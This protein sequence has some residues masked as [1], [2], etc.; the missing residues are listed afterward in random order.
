[1][2]SSPSPQKKPSSKKWVV[3]PTVILVLIVLSACLLTANYNTDTPPSREFYVGVEI[4]Y[5]SYSDLTAMVDEVKG[6]TNLVVLG[7]PEVSINQTLLDMSCNYIYD[8]GLHF[9]VLFTNLTQYKDWQNST[10]AQWV[11]DAKQRYGDRFL[12]VYRWDEAGGD[13]LDRSKYQEVKSA[14]SYA[15]AA[16]GYVEVLAPELEYYQE[17]GQEVLTAD[18]GLYWFDYRAGYDVVLAE[19]GWNN[20]REQQIALCRGA[21]RTFDRDWGA[22]V[23]WTYSNFSGSP[24]IGSA[25]E[26]Y[27]DLLMAYNCGAKYAVVF[28]YPQLASAE[29]GIL[30][31][32]HLDALKSFWSYI[33]NHPPSDPDSGKVHTAYVL[34]SDYGFGFRRPD[35]T[36]WG[37]WNGDDQT[38]QIYGDVE[39]LITQHGTGFDIVCNYPNLVA[40]LKGRYD[41][42]IFWNGTKIAQD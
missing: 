13:Q 10:P 26:L 4:A 42:L 33:S 1:M 25:P 27:S 2:Q 20:S 6:Y 30:T 28:N 34:P 16:E 11:A 31:Q 3:L 8:A 14:D 21:A 29:F 18:Y 37:L 22:I 5:G 32:E 17:A 7:L 12:A 23:T 24:F 19:F 39:A 9:V 15:E 41:A 38:R 36:V 35:D 40:D